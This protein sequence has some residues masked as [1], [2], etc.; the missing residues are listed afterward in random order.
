MKI[1]PVFC[2]I[3]N[4]I[5]FVNQIACSQQTRG[6]TNGV[7]YQQKNSGSLEKLDSGIDSS[8]YLLLFRDSLRSISSKELNAFNR[9]AIMVTDVWYNKLDYIFMIITLV[10]AIIFGVGVFNA[11]DKQTLIRQGI[12]REDEFRKWYQEVKDIVYEIKQQKNEILE[13]GVNQKNELMNY[14]LDK[15]NSIDHK[16]NE[17]QSE[18]YRYKRESRLAYRHLIQD[19]LDTLDNIIQDVINLKYSTDADNENGGRLL[20]QGYM[21]LIFEH[22][23]I[24][25]LYVF[26]LNNIS[27]YGKL[28]KT[29]QA[30]WGCGT[31]RSK[32]HLR[33]LADKL[34]RIYLEKDIPGEKKQ[35]DKTIRF[36]EQVILDIK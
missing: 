30:L 3:I 23:H 17:L 31:Y 26:D 33:F 22:R 7:N 2:F 35:I 13:V 10:F 20:Y 15:K 19:I 11:F 4:I 25:G 16:I 36:V 29:I 14:L 6:D 18:N 24:M 1:F 27:E 34:R 28:H 8:N 9:E 21:D 12:K 5:L 32:D